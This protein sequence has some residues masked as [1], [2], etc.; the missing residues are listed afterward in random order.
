MPAVLKS[1]VI[2]TGVISKQHLSFLQACDRSNLVGVCD[3][4][5]A[6]V[7]YA[8]DTF[9]AAAAYT[10][11]AQMLEIEKPDVV[12]ILTPPQTHLSIATDC[13]RSGAHVIC[14]KPVAPTYSEFKDLWQISRECDRFLIED[15][16]YRFN[17]PVRAIQALI[18][19]GMLG[20]VQEIEIRM[21]LDLRS[22]GRYADEN[23]P[24]PIHKMPAGVIHDFITHLSYL[25]LSFM[26][27]STPGF[28]AGFEAGFD[29]VS[30]A[31]SNHGGG[32]LFKYDDLDALVVAGQVHGRIRFSSYT[33]PDC[34]SIIVRGSKGYAETD[35][36]QPYLRCV[37]PRSVGKQLSPLVNHFVSGWELMSAS[38]RNFRSKIMQRN[39]YD[40]LHYLLGETYEALS[41][42]Q[43]PPIG[44]NDMARTSRLV[45]ALLAQENR[46]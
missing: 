4:S 8:V 43:A 46:L 11:Y 19:D 2:G 10:D 38:V 27:Q 25:L 24:N 17:G 39:A 22:G 16:N 35:L 15:H 36:F 21:A 23:L 7:H 45:E 20:E 1:A 40:G 9:Q 44:F 34:F 6:A 3:L 12:H 37:V 28:E 29:R 18:D 30:A 14:E 32:D 41:E 31:W 42:G 5:P 26:P 13:L 33:A